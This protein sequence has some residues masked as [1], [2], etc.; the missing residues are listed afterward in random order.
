MAKVFSLSLH[1]LPLSSRDFLGKSQ[2]PAGQATRAVYTG[3][4]GG[5]TVTVN[6][7]NLLIRHIVPSRGKCVFSMLYLL[8][9]LLRGET[10]FC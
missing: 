2:P 9:S 3:W 6:Q 7:E 5:Y 10:T 8:L 1:A 4:T